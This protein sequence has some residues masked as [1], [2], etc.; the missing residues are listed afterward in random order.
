VSYKYTLAA[1]KTSESLS[2]FYASGLVCDKSHN[3][4]GIQLTQPVS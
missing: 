2:F 3:A 1:P 4:F